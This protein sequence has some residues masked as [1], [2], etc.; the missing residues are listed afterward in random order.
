MRATLAGALMLGTYTSVGRPSVAHQG[1][2]GAVVASRRGDDPCLAEQTFVAGAQHPVEGAAR[3]ERARPLQQ[4]ELQHDTGFERHHRR[5]A[6]EAGDAAR[7]RRDVVAI[8]GRHRATVTRADAST[9]PPSP[10]NQI[11]TPSSMASVIT[12][13]W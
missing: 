8:D 3:F 5:S 4:F 6:D 11:A 1:D 12:P 10:T 13:T 9:A 2:G 7:R